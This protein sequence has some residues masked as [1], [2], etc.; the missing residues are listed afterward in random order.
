MRKVTASAVILTAITGCSQS[1]APSAQWRFEAPTETATA[2]SQSD[3][4]ASGGAADSSLDAQQFSLG[5]SR[6]RM[7]PAFEQPGSTDSL[8]TTNPGSLSTEAT[9]AST[10]DEVQ[11][12][13]ASQSR[14][15]PIGP[16]RAHLNASRNAGTSSFMGDRVPYSSRVYLPSAPIYAPTAT[17]AEEPVPIAFSEDTAQAIANFNQQ[18]SSLPRSQVLSTATA[19]APA[20]LPAQPTVQPVASLQTAANANFTSV[21]P[22]N[23][24]V[25]SSS[26]EEG[27]PVL[28][29][30]Q[31]QAELAERE[32]AA[33]TQLVENRTSPRENEGVPIGTSILRNIQVHA[34]LNSPSEI[35]TTAVASTVV[36]RELATQNLASENLA[37]QN[38]ASESLASDNLAIENLA[39]ESLSAGSLNAESGESPEA[40]DAL[41]FA[42]S[43]ASLAA[44]SS[45]EQASGRLT[46]AQLVQTIPQRKE[47]FEEESLIASFQTAR[48][49]LRQ[50][51]TAHSSPFLA[52]VSDSVPSELEA[53]E[54]ETLRQTLRPE[55]NRPRREIDSPLLEGLEASDDGS[56]ALQT[57]YMPIPASLLP[58]VSAMLI[59]TAIDTL[60]SNVD[61]AI[62]LNDLKAGTVTTLIDSLI[63]VG[64]GSESPASQIPAVPAVTPDITSNLI[65]ARPNPDEAAQLISFE[66]DRPRAHSTQVK[67]SKAKHSGNLRPA[68]N[69]VFPISAQV[70]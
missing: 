67:S 43:Y 47:R 49:N 29:A 59:R 15:D 57:L 40:V 6:S 35:S 31:P 64:Y 11:A 19:Q 37:T 38:L 39:T 53:S 46:L 2:F 12:L 51:S 63:P 56:G 65:P 17:F 45:I 52:D 62:L 1:K 69:S 22:S 34:A 50:V 25:A 32:S 4:F 48:E 20:Q 10:V 26:F 58:E 55:A 60:S 42:T 33:V 21:I 23:A 61:S 18:D 9:A 14:T 41:D 8:P 28:P 27:L 16:V 13:L 5:T 66:I 44:G 54:L 68:Q 3:V 24:T 7:G 70:N 30:A 36:A